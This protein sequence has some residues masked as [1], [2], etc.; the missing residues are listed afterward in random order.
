MEKLYLYMS[1]AV[2][3]INLPVTPN[4]A[5]KQKRSIITPPTPPP[6][7]FGQHCFVIC[8]TIYKN[9]RIKFFGFLYVVVSCPPIVWLSNWV[10]DNV[11]FGTALLWFSGWEIRSTPDFIPCLSFTNTCH[12]CQECR[13]WCFRGQNQIKFFE[14][15]S[16]RTPPRSSRRIASAGLDR[17][18][19]TPVNLLFGVWPPFC[20]T[21]LSSPS[22]PSCVR[23]H[24]QYC[25]PW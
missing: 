5:T 3:E 23:A 6:P 15:A 10:K 25:Y 7:P 18:P 12:L 2:R 9:N 8:L 24:E 1:T 11:H 16:S 19:H 22:S 20:A 4:V 17:H 14:E 13:K 21:P